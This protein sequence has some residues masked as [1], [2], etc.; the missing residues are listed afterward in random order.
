MSAPG[1]ESVIV[2]TKK[3]KPVAN[4][5]SGSTPRLPRKLTKNDSRTAMPLIV[6]GTSSTRKS[7][8]PI[9]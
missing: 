6:N 9:T 7:S 5:R 1:I 8:G 3:R 4:A 2:T